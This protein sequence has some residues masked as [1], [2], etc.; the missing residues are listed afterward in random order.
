MSLEQVGRL[1]KP[2]QTK[3]FYLSQEGHSS[4][5]AASVDINNA[6]C[7]GLD[8]LRRDKTK[9]VEF[10]FRVPSEM[11]AL[12]TFQYEMFDQLVNFHN[13][14]SKPDSYVHPLTLMTYDP[15]LSDI[16]T[17]KGAFKNIHGVGAIEHEL[18]HFKGLKNLWQHDAQ[19]QFL[20]E[21]YWDK[22]GKNHM[23]KTWAEFT[24]T[25]QRNKYD[26]AYVLSAPLYPSPDDLLRIA[27]LYIQARK[28]ALLL[29]ENNLLTLLNRIVQKQNIQ[30]IPGIYDSELTHIILFNEWKKMRHN[31]IRMDTWDKWISHLL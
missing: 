2:I 21:L 26:E 16:V 24:P 18:E 22:I 9:K 25:E 29:G 23:L 19:G 17:K 30:P 4:L 12:E 13:T 3:R 27:S 6:I 15:A 7:S 5:P 28:F 10:V 1:Y 14:T 20:F 8:M 31:T 11:G